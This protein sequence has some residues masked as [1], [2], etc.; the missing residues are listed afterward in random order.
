M[1]DVEAVAY[2]WYQENG[3]FVE[4]DVITNTKDNQSYI[5]LSEN[6]KWSV[7]NDIVTQTTN[8]DESSQE[9]F[10]VEVLKYKIVGETLF[11]TYSDE[12]QEV[13]TQLQRAT[14]DKMQGIIAKAKKA[15]I[16]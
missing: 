15:K 8:F 6:G 13:T 9:E 11:M 2:M 12:G 7:E 14:I 3:N 5:E 10:D 1:P 16:E 4:A